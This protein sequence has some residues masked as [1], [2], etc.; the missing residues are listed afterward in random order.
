M[1]KVASPGKD[2]KG[3]KRTLSE[4]EREDR[5][6]E[7]IESAK[8]ARDRAETDRVVAQFRELADPSLIGGFVTIQAR[9]IDTGKFRVSLRDIDCVSG[10]RVI[11]NSYFLMVGEDGSLAS[12]PEFKR[13]VFD[14]EK[15]GDKAE[16]GRD[17]GVG[18][19]GG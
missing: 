16:D 19:A 13:R 17:Q 18:V 10:E 2:G 12:N 7:R 9:K 4:W 8:V 6:R 1:S 5:E 11:A 15:S 14:E 3:N